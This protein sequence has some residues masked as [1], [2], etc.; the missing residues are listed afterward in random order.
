MIHVGQ[1]HTDERNII[2]QQI[3]ILRCIQQETIQPLYNHYSQLEV[4]LSIVSKQTNNLD[5][6][7]GPPHKWT[8]NDLSEYQTLHYKLHKNIVETYLLVFQPWE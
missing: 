5:N 4:R 8:I 3:F 2:Q 6:D 7:Y 1:G